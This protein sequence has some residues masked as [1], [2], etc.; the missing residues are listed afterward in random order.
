MTDGAIERLRAGV[1]GRDYASMARLAKALYDRKLRTREVLHECYGADFPSEF[2]AT[3][4][5]RLR[6]PPLLVIFTN[7]PWKLVT[8]GES[9]PPSA[10]SEELEKRIFARDPDLVPLV[11]LI[12]SRTTRERPVMC[13]RLS[14]LRAGRT[15]VFSIKATATARDPIT[16]H[17]E[18]LL[19]VVRAHHANVLQHMEWL[20]DQPWN[21]GFGAEDEKAIDEVRSLLERIEELQR[22]AA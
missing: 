11:R 13:Y 16:R 7:L 17:G 22:Q 4:G 20:V 3:A 6:R 12:G 8:L 15:A 5:E 10:P 2:F 18:S 9:S 14:E 19:D 21:R 1:S